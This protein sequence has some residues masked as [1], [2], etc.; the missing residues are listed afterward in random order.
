MFLSVLFSLSSTNLEAENLCLKL[1]SPYVIFLS[2]TENS[3]QSPESYSR[4]YP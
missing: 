1:I 3:S 2:G 4:D